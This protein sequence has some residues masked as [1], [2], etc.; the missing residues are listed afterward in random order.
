MVFKGSNP[1]EADGFSKKIKLVMTPFI[2]IVSSNCDASVHVSCLNTWSYL[3]YKLDKLASSH[4]V[5]KTV[6]E[7]ILEVIIKVGPVNKNIW[8]WSFCI[9]LLDNFISAG[10]KDLNSKL[11]D[12]KAMRLPQ[13]A[14]FSWKYYPIKWSPLDLG[15]L[16]FFLNTIHGLIIHRST[17]TLSGEV[18]T[19]TYGAASS[20][21]RS[22][23]RSVKHFLKSDLIT[24][25]EVILSLNMMLKFL[26]SIYENMHSRDGGIDDLLPLLR[27]LL[28]AFV[29][30]LEPSTLQSPLY[31]VP[32]D[33][34]DI[35]T[36]E[37]VYI[38]KSAKIPEICFMNCMEKVSPVAYITL[39]YF[40]AV[41]KETL[42]APDYDIVE[43]KHRY[44]KLLLSSYEPSEILHLFV[45][46]LYSKKMPHCFEIWVA[47]ANC[48]KDSIDNHRFHSLFKLHSD[49]PGYATTIHF[50]C[51][52]FAA[53]SGPKVHLKF[54]HIIEVWKSLY[55]SL[56]GA[57]D[58]GD[59]TLTED[60]FSMLCSYFN[61]ALTNGDLIPEPQSSVKGQDIDVLLLFGG[62]MICAVEQASLIAK[63]EAK[64]CE[65]W[66][67]SNIK[68]SLEFASW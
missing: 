44:V 34:K 50:L 59:P 2:G 5:V 57:S 49:S 45:S 33:L 18:R 10:N 26:E 54:Q 14:K 40:H 31:K 51:Y 25:D 46:L 37:P 62:A 64:E 61:E 24:Y 30:E 16:E 1:T 15:K 65:S 38:F 67:S 13:S 11:N 53:Y 41:T 27:Q 58:I 8:S 55:I 4:S 39:L 9:E 66:R 56:S 36:S 22:L 60:L 19:V 23:L 52:P 42:K 63:S 28:E 12:H 20:L 68:S 47:L 32:L 43:G 29:E 35:E 3:L 21:F 48:L 17:I 7:P 6:W